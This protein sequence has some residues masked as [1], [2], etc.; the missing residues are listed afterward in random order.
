ME[1][2]ALRFIEDAPEDCRQLAICSIITLIMNAN[3]SDIIPMRTLPLRLG[4]LNYLMHA[5]DN[6]G[7]QVLDNISKHLA[8]P[9]ETS[10]PDRIIHLVH[11]E[12]AGHNTL[13]EGQLPAQLSKYLADDQGQFVWQLQRNRINTLWKSTHS[14]HTFWTATS[15]STICPIRFHLPWGLIIGDIVNHG[16]GL[17]HCGLA[18]HGDS[19]M[20]FLAPPSGGKSTTLSSAP[21]G[22]QVLSD[23]AALVWRSNSGAWFAS[24]LPAWGN[25]IRPDDGWEYP[26]LVTYQPCR[27]KSLLLI[28]K[29]NSI[30]LEK[31]VP[32]TVVPSVFRSLCEY[33]ATITAEAIQKEAF[34]RSAA[35]MSREL[36]SWRLSLP[37]YGN[38]WPLLVAEAA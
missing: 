11:D 32:S 16:G 9:T 13:A 8:T 35:R 25:M 7:K 33:P 15:A 23:D 26:N 29:A 34:F 20:L 27:I 4:P 31:L 1:T 30:S 21:P 5:H 24:P 17:L 38:V 6:W 3:F 14:Q 28:E 36:R 18:R 22:W 12:D 10:A 2:P 37:L 19:G